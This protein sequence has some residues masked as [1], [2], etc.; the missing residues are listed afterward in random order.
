[1]LVLTRKV[2]E[3]IVIGDDVRVTILE[4]K[5]GRVRIGIEAPR[6]KK[7]YR[8]EVYER[9]CQ[10]NRAASQW[11]VDKMDALNAVLPDSGEC[12]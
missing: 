4:D 6:D 11:D 5:E 8:Q 3:G 10:E 1:M 12:K 7:I 9:I 2:G